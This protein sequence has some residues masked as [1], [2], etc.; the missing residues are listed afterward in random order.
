VS[1]LRVIAADKDGIRLIVFA[2]LHPPPDFA[3]IDESRKE[4]RLIGTHSEHIRKLEPNSLIFRAVYN[5]DKRNPLTGKPY[6]NQSPISIGAVDIGVETSVVFLIIRASGFTD[7][8][9]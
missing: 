5:T 6:R 9:R 2:I 3:H 7:Q 1:S 8:R 4:K